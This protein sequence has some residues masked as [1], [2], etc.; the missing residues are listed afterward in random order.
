MYN[1]IVF[2]RRGVTRM[3]LSAILFQYAHA[4]VRAT[5]HALT[6]ADLIRTRSR[7]Y[8]AGKSRS[9]F[10]FIHFSLYREPWFVIIT[11]DYQYRF[12]SAFRE[13]WK[14]HARCRIKYSKF[15][16]TIENAECMWDAYTWVMFKDRDFSVLFNFTM[17]IEIQFPCN[18]CWTM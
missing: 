18:A 8:V 3:D 16:T 12:D 2:V 4:D 7:I 11:T 14:I 10:R 5:T 13:Y 17:F 1:D 15:I 6:I 9:G